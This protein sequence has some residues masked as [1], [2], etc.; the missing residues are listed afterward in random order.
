MLQ[1]GLEVNQRTERLT[2]LRIRLLRLLKHSLSKIDE[3]VLV[4]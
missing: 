1:M 3:G 2:E 4:D